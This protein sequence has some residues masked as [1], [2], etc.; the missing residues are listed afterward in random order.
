MT[1]RQ[2][3]QEQEVKENSLELMAL[4]MQLTSTLV[5]SRDSRTDN[6]LDSRGRGSPSSR[7]RLSL[8]TLDTQSGQS[9][10]EGALDFQCNTIL[11][12]QQEGPSRLGHVDAGLP[13]RPASTGSLGS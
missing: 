9:H 5:C 3:S 12:S 13:P 4:R 7:P 11:K 10:L 1:G 6:T 8:P 2:M